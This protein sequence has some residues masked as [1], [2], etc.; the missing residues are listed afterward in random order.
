MSLVAASKR[1]IT[2]PTISVHVLTHVAH[3]GFSI[4]VS[5]SSTP[6]GSINDRGRE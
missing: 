2:I 1:I 3:D 5:R 4:P 6:G